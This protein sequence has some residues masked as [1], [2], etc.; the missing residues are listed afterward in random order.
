MSHRSGPGLRIVARRCARVLLAAMLAALGMVQGAFAQAFPQPGK[1]LRIIVPFPAGGQT[2]IQARALAPKLQAQLGVPVIIDNKPGASTFIGTQELVRSAPDG[3]TIMYTIG[4]T[5]MQNPHLYAKLPYDAFKDLA[6]LMFAARSGTVLIVPSAAPYNS[7][8]ELVAYAKANPGKLNFGSFSN[9]SASHLYGELLKENTGIYMVHIP[10][11]GSGDASAALIGNQVQ[12]LFDGPTTAINMAKAGRAKMLGV[13]D[14]KRL[15]AL[16]EVPTMAEAGVPGLDLDGGMMFY[17]PAKTPSE[18][19]KRLNDE[20]AKALKDP[21][22]VALYANGGTE[23]VAS[24]PEELAALNRRGYDTW[25]AL[26]KK[27]GIKLD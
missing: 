14:K 15:A 22:V 6:P 1:P 20:L 26:I 10:Y 7:V 23:I 12:L 21:A 13:T 9:G 27:L 5:V 8:K 18:T 17:A 19:I 4:V 25:G 16:P 2:D 24:S 3:H 11:K